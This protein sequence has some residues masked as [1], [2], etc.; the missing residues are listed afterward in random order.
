MKPLGK[1]DSTAAS[2]FADIEFKEYQDLYRETYV[3]TKDAVKSYNYMLSDD[4]IYTLMRWVSKKA[5]P[6]DAMTEGY[7]RMLVHHLVL[8]R[9]YES[10]N[11]A[12]LTV[13][14]S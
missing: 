9:I 5:W 11:P 3:G 12:D 14:K 4:I 10:S 8:F 1:K 13:P 7:R 2:K 6:R